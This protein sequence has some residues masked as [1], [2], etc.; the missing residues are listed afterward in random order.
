[1]IHLFAGTD[2]VRNRTE[3]Y[4][5]LHAAGVPV[6]V[7]D[8]E[9]YQPGQM[10]DVVRSR[11]LFSDQAGYLIDRPSLEEAFFAETRDLLAEMADSPDMFVIVEGKLTA[12]LKKTYTPFA[13]SVTE[14]DEKAE[15][16]FPM[17]AA[18]DALLNRDKRT[19]WKLVT[20]GLLSGASAEEI[21]GILWWQLKTLRVV[22]KS[23]SPEAAG[24]KPF[25]Y[26][27][28]KR[29]L[30]RFPG[31]DLERLSLSLLTAYHDGRN[32]RPIELA[33]EAWVLSV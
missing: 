13:A 33:L 29:A 12:A 20:E 19:L 18:A 21:I 6:E 22:A 30:S 1:M 10:I 32:D 16:G 26:D 9:V 23:A 27:K 2:Q 14:H 25:V 11:S 7:V 15:A 5:L 4:A 17:F 28:S 3:A 8:A 24:V 31:D